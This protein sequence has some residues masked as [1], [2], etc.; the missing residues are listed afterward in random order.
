MVV[1]FKPWDSH[2]LPELIAFVGQNLPNQVIDGLQILHLATVPI[3]LSSIPCDPI[4]A[5][6]LSNAIHLKENF[7]R[8]IFV[9]CFST[10]LSSS[11]TLLAPVSILLALV[12]KSVSHNQDN[13]S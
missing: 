13:R 8:I 5:L 2:S 4:G 12:V 3:S 7:S 1:E 11:S 10:F 9:I 6:Q